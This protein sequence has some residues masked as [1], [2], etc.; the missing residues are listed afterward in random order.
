MR[1]EPL[2]LIQ[3]R[4]VPAHLYA[5]QLEADVIEAIASHVQEDY[6]TL[7]Q[8]KIDPL[9]CPMH[10]RHAVVSILPLAYLDATETFEGNFT[11]DACCPEFHQTVAAQLTI[12]H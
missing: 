6:R 11:I 2:F 5:R 1:I 4:E 7:A 10:Q 8:Q 3:G 9:V 12:S